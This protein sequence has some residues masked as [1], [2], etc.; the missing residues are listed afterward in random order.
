MK[1]SRNLFIGITMLA[2]SLICSADGISSQKAKA[3]LHEVGENGLPIPKVLLHR[4]VQALGGESA[5]RAYKSRTVSGKF[6]MPAFGVEGDLQTVAEA[7]GKIATTVNMGDF[8]ISGNG[9]DGVTGW[10]IN[11]MTGNKVLQGQ[12][13]EAAAK[14]ADFYAD[15]HHGLN[16]MKQETVEIASLQGNAA[17]RVR[18]EQADGEESFLFFSKETG[19]LVGTDSMLRT[20]TGPVPTS[21]RFSEYSEFGGVKV[22]TRITTQQAGIESVIEINSVTF[23]DVSK[24]AFELPVVIKA[25]VK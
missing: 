12:A 25:L 23:D 20:P 5:I 6:L 14:Q 8:G 24:D 3:Q 10:D 11:P 21:N 1:T 16:A 18:L 15:L 17:Y 7:S 19:L 13:L 4:H 9:Y 2:F 22:A